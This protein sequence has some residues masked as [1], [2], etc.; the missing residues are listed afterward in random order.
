MRR[1]DPAPTPGLFYAILAGMGMCWLWL[2]HLETSL[3]TLSDNVASRDDFIALE[4]KVDMLMAPAEETP[5]EP[6]VQRPKPKKR[7]TH[8][9]ETMRAVPRPIIQTWRP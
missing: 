4:R 6:S 2:W 3:S 1:R 7:T 9:H 8:P 5:V